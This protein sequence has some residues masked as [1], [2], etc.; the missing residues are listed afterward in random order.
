MA[1]PCDLFW[2]FLREVSDW[3]PGQPATLG[4]AFPFWSSGERNASYVAL[5]IERYRARE[6][7]S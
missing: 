5:C 7:R 4:E 3:I 6:A 1:R 2:P